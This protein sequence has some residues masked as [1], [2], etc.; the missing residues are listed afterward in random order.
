MFF[1][2]N[3]INTHCKKDIKKWFISTSQ[4]NPNPIKLFQYMSIWFKLLNLLSSE[5]SLSGD[6]SCE[7][8]ATAW[9]TLQLKVDFYIQI[10]L[11]R[12]I[13]THTH[14]ERRK[15]EKTSTEALNSATT[16]DIKAPETSV[17]MSVFPPP[18]WN[19]TCVLTWWHHCRTLSISQHVLIWTFTERNSGASQV[20]SK[21]IG[22]CVL[23]LWYTKVSYRYLYSV[24]THA[25]E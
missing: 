13:H 1:S 15:K 18:K 5:N 2:T 11:S 3:Y 4:S 6:S 17:A 7:A 24:L 21:S 8:T 10:P 14:R 20:T 22:R 9:E 19:N 23:W 16:G 25:A 12:R